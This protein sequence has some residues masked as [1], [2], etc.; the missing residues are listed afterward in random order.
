MLELEIVI[1]TFTQRDLLADNF[2]TAELSTSI[3]S[4]RE[5][6]RDRETGCVYECGIVKG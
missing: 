5:A 4:E 1:L 3:P 6:G 2:S